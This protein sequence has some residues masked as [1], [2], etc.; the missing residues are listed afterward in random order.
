M[1]EIEKYTFA[2]RH[3]P[4][5]PSPFEVRLVGKGRG[6]I[7]YDDKDIV[8]FGKTFDEAAENVMKQKQICHHL[9]AESHLDKI[10]GC[11]YYYTCRDCGSIWNDTESPPK[12]VPYL[13]TPH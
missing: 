9:R 11:T 10:S 1:N 5:C 6:R 4:N 8:G 7:N 2:V 3:N 13:N 12:N